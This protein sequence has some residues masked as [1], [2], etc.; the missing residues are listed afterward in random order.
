VT[1][2]DVALAK[3]REI[4]RR[5]EAAMA[6]VRRRINPT[7]M[8]RPPRSSEEREWLAERGVQDPFVEVIDYVEA[9]RAYF[10]AKYGPPAA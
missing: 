3:L 7:G 6:E 2:N 4:W 1:N 5:R 9:Y 8:T 10:R